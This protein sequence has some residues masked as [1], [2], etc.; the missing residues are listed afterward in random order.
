MKE[1]GTAMEKMDPPYTK[2]GRRPDRTQ[3]A[4][5]A[6]RISEKRKRVKRQA[7][8]ETRDVLVNASKDESEITS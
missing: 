3:K 6:L 2:I 7:Q 5:L 4:E 1:L 8:K